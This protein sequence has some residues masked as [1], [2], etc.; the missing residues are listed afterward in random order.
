MC[1]PTV[2]HGY[3]LVLLIN[4]ILSMVS[5]NNVH[6]ANQLHISDAKESNISIDHKAHIFREYI[7]VFNCLSGFNNRLV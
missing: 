1:I 3:L 5:L 2:A 6:Y 7:S 4:S